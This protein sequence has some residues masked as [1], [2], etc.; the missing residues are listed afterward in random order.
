M[1][2]YRA[3]TPESLRT[4]LEHALAAS[5]PA[6][7]EIPTNNFTESSPWEFIMPPSQSLRTSE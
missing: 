4:S 2:G 7:I 3:E 5:A 1:R 6:L